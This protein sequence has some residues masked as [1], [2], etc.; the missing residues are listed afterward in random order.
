MLMEKRER[1]INYY[2]VLCRELNE[3]G[4]RIEEHLD[5]RLYK[6]EYEVDESHPDLTMMSITRNRDAYKHLKNAGLLRNNMCQICGELPVDSTYKFTE[7][8]N[9]ISLNICRNCHPEGKSVNQ[10]CDSGC[11]FTI[12]VWLVTALCTV[13]VV[14]Y[15]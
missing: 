9:K 2:R 4:F 10:S 14:S 6:L 3:N 12:L 13:T 8:T 15:L 7:P 5:G 1:I 11:A